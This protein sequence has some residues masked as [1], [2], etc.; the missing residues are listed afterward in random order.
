MSPRR[1]LMILLL[2]TLAITINLG[3]AAS[4]D[5]P[6]PWS[7]EEREVEPIIVTGEWLEPLGG[8]SLE[9]LFVYTYDG[10]TWE[11]IPWQ[12]DEVA[13]GVIVSSEDG[14]LDGDDELVFMAVD[15]GL[16]APAESWIDDPGS[17]Q[18]ARCEIEVTDPLQPSDRGWAYVY[19]SDSDSRAFAAD[20][21]D[22]DETVRTFSSDRY[23]LGMLP[24]R[25]VADRLEL[26]GSGVDILD[27]WKGRL[28]LS[29]GLWYTEEYPVLDSYPQVVDGPVRAVAARQTAYFYL[30][31]L[32]YRTGF[33]YVLHLPLGTATGMRITSMRLTADFTSAVG[34]STYYDENTPSG[35]LVDGQPDAVKTSP[36]SYWFQLSGGTG[37]V[38]A[39]TWPAYL[40]GTASTYYRDNATIDPND[41]GDKR[42]YGECGLSI[43]DPYSDVRLT[44]Y[45]AILPGRQPNQRRLA[46]IYK[47]PE[48]QLQFTVA[49]QSY[50]SPTATPTPTAS[51]SPTATV[52]SSATAPLAQGGLYLP[53]LMMGM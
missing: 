24:G 37:T 43:L 44:V 4:A 33:Q 11:Q 38:I 40:G 53:L 34:G 31:T 12:F 19:R 49:Q 27:R 32:A 41:T 50:I 8:A 28:R 16:K 46:D 35:V 39:G 26:Y 22:Y 7:A 42:S 51:A 5:S 21:V 23:L 15:V 48:T 25:V 13:S 9:R 52:T 14:R 29:N 36:A 20:Y 2:A 1:L 17:R 18:H 30:T 45:H 3:P 10:S 6:L 47:D